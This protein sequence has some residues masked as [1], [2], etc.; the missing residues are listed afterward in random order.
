VPGGGSW[1]QR[2]AIEFLQLGYFLTAFI[3]WAAAMLLI[4]GLF[5]LA[6]P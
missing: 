2:L 5:S 1:L 4:V 6:N 3:V